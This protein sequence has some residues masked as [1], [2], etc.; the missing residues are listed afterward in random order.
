[1]ASVGA[2]NGVHLDSSRLMACRQRPLPE[3]K[4]V[5]ASCHTAAQLQHACNIGADFALLSPVNKTASHPDAV[6]LGWDSFR[7]MC[8]EINI[9]VYALGGMTRE[10]LDISRENGAQGIA[11]IRSLWGHENVFF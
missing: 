4:L 9:P 3:E 10:H 1:V 2:A 11:A 5:A 8:D 6:P 7:V